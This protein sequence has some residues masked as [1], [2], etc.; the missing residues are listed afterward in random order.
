MGMGFIAATIATLAALAAPTK[1][2]PVARLVGPKMHKT[3]STTLGG[4]LA[5]A[6][7]RY[8]WTA[9]LYG[10]MQ[11]IEE[12]PRFG[13]RSLPPE[14]PD[15]LYCHVL[16][17]ANHGNP[18]DFHVVGKGEKFA[19]RRVANYTAPRLLAYL[20]FVVP[21]ARLVLALREPLGR[22]VSMMNY[23]TYAERQF[24]KDAPLFTRRMVDGKLEIE[25]VP[26]VDRLFEIIRPLVARGLGAEYM[27]TVLGLRTREQTDAFANSKAFADAA[28]LVTSHMDESLVVLRRLLDWAPDDVL[29]LDVHVSCEDKVR[30]DG[31][32]VACVD[33]NLS[34]A[35]EA[36][37]ERMLALHAN[38]RALYAAARV[39]VAARFD[40]LG[41]GGAAELARLRARNGALRAYCDR[42]GPSSTYR[43]DA[44]IFESRDPCVPFLMNDASFP[45]YLKA[46]RPFYAFDGAGFTDAKGAR[47]PRL[48]QSAWR[49]IEDVEAAK[50]D[51]PGGRR[52]RR[53]SLSHDERVAR[54]RARREQAGARAAAPGDDDKVPL[55][56]RR[57]KAR[58]GA[59]VVRVMRG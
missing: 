56:E 15:I 35:P 3:G 21:G 34:G 2:E 37:R 44:A 28:I 7:N 22:Y 20:D 51:A 49:S 54:A 38:D 8:G 47:V 31:R 14:K 50:G 24:S 42:G 17:S 52:R 13:P 53:P 45:V 23:F 58:Y 1:P 40:A 12:F 18:A 57:R 39:A 33:A 9:R 46:R 27:T 26:E 4:I 55:W 32:H 48:N 29:H 11:P 43:P 30:W 6:S 5:R 25:P 59:D 36:L 19:L 10:T 16:G 41:P